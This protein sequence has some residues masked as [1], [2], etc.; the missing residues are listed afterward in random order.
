MAAKDKKTEKINVRDLTYY[1]DSEQC[2]SFDLGKINRK[3]YHWL[4][5]REKILKLPEDSFNITLKAIES[6]IDSAFL[7]TDKDDKASVKQSPQDK[8]ALYEVYTNS[9]KTASGP[10]LSIKSQSRV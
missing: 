2:L 3:N 5:L 4:N 1:F 9:K 6:L 8:K 7:E 10:D